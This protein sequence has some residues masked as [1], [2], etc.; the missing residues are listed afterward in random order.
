MNEQ[1]VLVFSF[2][3]SGTIYSSTGLSCFF[4]GVY[5][6]QTKAV[7]SVISRLQRRPF[8]QLVCL[9]FERSSPIKSLAGWWSKSLSLLSPAVI[10]TFG[11]AH[12]VD[13]CR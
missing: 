7:E 9:G 13:M 8:F 3:L 6:T 2:R 5:L 1:P 10:S 11:G 12:H 4:L